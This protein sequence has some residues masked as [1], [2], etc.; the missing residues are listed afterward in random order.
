MMLLIEISTSS[1][2]F[3]SFPSFL[4]TERKVEKTYPK[5]G[6]RKLLSYPLLDIYGLLSQFS[7][8]NFFWLDGSGSSPFLLQSVSL[9]HHENNVLLLRG[10]KKRRVIY[11]FCDVL[12]SRGGG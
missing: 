12:S 5:N 8:S 6:Q 3:S 10:S 11:T 1:P 4:T 7:V 2:S 9:S